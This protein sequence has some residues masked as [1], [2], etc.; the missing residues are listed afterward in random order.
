M[1]R[2]ATVQRLK[3]LFLIA[4]LLFIA[5]CS[6]TDPYRAA[7]GIDGT[8][9]AD[10]SFIGSDA[11]KDDANAVVFSI[12]PRPAATV[13]ANG[14][15]AGIINI[16]A[17][18]HKKLAIVKVVPGAATRAPLAVSMEAGAGTASPQHW[19]IAKGESISSAFQRWCAVSNYTLHW[20]VPD[21]IS[22]VDVVL[23]GTFDHAVQ[24]VIEAVND[25]ARPSG[26]NAPGTSADRHSAWFAYFY[27]SNTPKILRVL[28]Q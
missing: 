24:T 22:E 1:L 10:E 27:E 7:T 5:A 4:A 9:L 28:A 23:E 6:S 26:R 19:R 15:L 11:A 14:G 16:V 13:A 8:P 12:S 25:G 20:T 21:K 3:P 18:P 17:A 2:V